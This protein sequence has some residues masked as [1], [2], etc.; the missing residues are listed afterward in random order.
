MSCSV[1]QSVSTALWETRRTLNFNLKKPG[2]LQHECK[3]ATHPLFAEMYVANIFAWRL[4]SWGETVFGVVDSNKTR[5]VCTA[6]D[7]SN[8]KFLTQIAK[9][10]ST[11]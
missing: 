6:L 4:V 10:G 9:L 5:D 11:L 8:S 7:D 1:N 3:V 2:R